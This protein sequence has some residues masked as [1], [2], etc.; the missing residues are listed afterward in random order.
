[1]ADTGSLASADIRAFNRAWVRDIFATYPNID[2]IRPDWPE[3]PCYKLDEAF[4]DFSLHVAA[5]ASDHD[6]DFECIRQTS[7]RFYRYLHGSLTNR[8]LA[9][10]A[11]PDW[12]RKAGAKVVP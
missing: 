10:F 9:D 4:Q 11:T 8:D 6:F 1:M 3:Y 5:W 12:V 2:G 7:D